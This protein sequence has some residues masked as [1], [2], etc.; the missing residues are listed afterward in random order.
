MQLSNL[1][2]FQQLSLFEG[3]EKVGRVVDEIRERYG[4]SMVG[5]ADQLG[6]IGKTLVSRK[7]V[8]R[9]H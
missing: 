4:F 3:H 2:V 5:L 8:G 6:G 7:S 9:S 1:G